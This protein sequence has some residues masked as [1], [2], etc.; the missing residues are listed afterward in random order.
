MMRRCIVLALAS[1]VTAGAAY[2]QDVLVIRDGTRRQGAVRGCRDD[3]CTLN[4]VKVA[5]GLIAWVGLRQDDAAPP[6]VRDPLKDEV[7]LVDG[8][9]VNGEFG[10]LSLGALALGDDSYD[11]DEVAWIRFA[12]PEPAP[13]PRPSPS[14]PIY[15]FSPSPAASGSPGPSPPPTPPPS[16]PPPPPPPPGGP[17]IGAC[18]V[19]PYGFAAEPGGRWIGRMDGRVHTGGG[20][21]VNTHVDVRAPR[22]SVRS[23]VPSEIPR[24]MIAASMSSEPAIV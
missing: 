2:A 18:G 7:H 1:A 14:G 17:P 16:M 13:T 5:R 10:G 8:R 4:G 9:V 20:H 24:T 21:L 15:R 3:A 23:N 12:G 6:R 11:R 19:V 22:N